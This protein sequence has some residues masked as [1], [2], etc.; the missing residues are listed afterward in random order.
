MTRALAEGGREEAML[1]DFLLCFFEMRAGGSQ[2][3]LRMREAEA[4]KT[5]F[6]TLKRTWCRLRDGEPLRQSLLAVGAAILL[7]VA[8][9]SYLH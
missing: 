1:W 7:R 4:E 3:K 6:L 2:T 5:V 9:L 8:R